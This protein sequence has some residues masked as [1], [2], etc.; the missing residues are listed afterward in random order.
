MDFGVPKA[1]LPQNP[2]RVMDFGGIAPKSISDRDKTCI[3]LD[4]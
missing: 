2:Y 1:G 3:G 4:I